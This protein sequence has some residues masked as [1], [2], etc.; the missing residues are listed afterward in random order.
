MVTETDSKSVK[1]CENGS[2][3]REG[4]YLFIFGRIVLA[5]VLIYITLNIKGERRYCFLDVRQKQFPTL[6]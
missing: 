5:D 4:A 2:H 6:S 3:F 1:I